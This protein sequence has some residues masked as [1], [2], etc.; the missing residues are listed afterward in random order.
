M[1]RVSVSPTDLPMVPRHTPY[2]K[3]EREKMSRSRNGCLTCRI[4]RKVR[5]IMFRSSA[6]RTLNRYMSRNAL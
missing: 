5:S 1:S 2:E 6:F 3:K 4:R